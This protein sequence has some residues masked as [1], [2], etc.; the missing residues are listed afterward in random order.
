M[1]KRLPRVVTLPRV[2]ELAI[3][4]HLVCATGVLAGAAGRDI[5]REK[6]TVTVRV[7]KAG[8][9]RAFGDNHEVRAPIKSGSV[10]EGAQASVRVVISAPQ[11]RVVDPGLS[12]HDREE[13]QT[14]M[15]GPDVLDVAQ[16]PEIRFE[17]TNVH[18]SQS[19]RLSI[20][21]HLTLHGQ[22]QPVVVSVV[23]EH[24]HYRGSTT[25]KQ[26]AFGIKPVAVAGGTV[27]VK[28]EVTIEFDI[29]ILPTKSGP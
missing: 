27:K 19:D 18:G 11:M 10:D 7:S 8:V 26:T 24:D 20:D 14:R 3:T 15:L 28:D 16:F 1:M 29:V 5:D 25:V 17:S 23:R 12:P 13:V 21:G 4:A 6:S 9:F 2:L 22:T